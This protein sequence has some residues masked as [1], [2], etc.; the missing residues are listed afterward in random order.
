MCPVRAVREL[1]NVRDILAS[2]SL[3]G[4]W[5]EMGD[6]VRFG[7]MRLNRYNNDTVFE[8]AI[9]LDEIGAYSAPNFVLDW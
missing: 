3:P 7:S 1:W 5:E 2:R 8:S 9:N 4:A 6:Q